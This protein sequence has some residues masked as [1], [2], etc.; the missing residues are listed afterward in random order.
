MIWPRRFLC[1][2]EGTGVGRRGA[3][4]EKSAARQQSAK[5][6]SGPGAEGTGAGADF[7]AGARSAP[8]GS[9]LGPDRARARSPGWDVRMK[10]SLHPSAGMKASYSRVWPVGFLRFGEGTL[11]TYGPGHPEQCKNTGNLTFWGVVAG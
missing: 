9:R 4:A 6:G 2:G 8:A 3:P 7:F 5:I 1:S 11:A 10:S